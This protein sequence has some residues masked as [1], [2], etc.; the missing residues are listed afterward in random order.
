M[1]RPR[2]RT[3]D[4]LAV[5]QNVRTASFLLM[6]QSEISVLKLCRQAVYKTGDVRRK[7]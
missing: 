1:T 6:F 4:P 7:A 2:R 3:V 5:F